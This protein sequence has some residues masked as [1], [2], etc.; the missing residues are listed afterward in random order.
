MPRVLPAE[1]PIEDLL[2]LL[3]VDLSER[4]WGT[5][6]GLAWL[7]P[8]L[9][10]WL[11]DEV[12]ALNQADA[13]AAAGIGRGQYHVRDRS[14][15]RDRIAWLKGD[16]TPQEELFGLLAVLQR[17]L[18]ER[19]FLGLRRFEAH[20]ATYEPGDFYKR[21]LDSFQGRAS[22]VVS[23]VLYLNEA[24]HATDGGALQIFN[25]ESPSEI[26]ATVLPE[27]GRLAVFMSEE[28]PHEVLTAQRTRHSLACWFRCD[29]VA[30]PL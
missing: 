12:I 10:T 8:A 24:W 7:T 1:A 28:I 16:T 13:M 6:D 9:V 3:A 14:V 25:R 21:H 26:C 30:L 4:G 29:E 5:L 19:L 11:R 18:N 20:Y 17:G 15:R 22:R 2:D 23:L 27:G